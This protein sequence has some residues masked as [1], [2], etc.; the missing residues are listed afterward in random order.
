VATSD[1][2]FR[3]GACPTPEY[4]IAYTGNYTTSADAN[5]EARKRVFVDLLKWELPILADRFEVDQFDDGRA[6]YLIVAD[7]HRRHLASARLL[8]T[9]RPALLDSLFPD[10]V[11]GLP[12]QGSDV[13]EITRFCLSREAGA[14]GRRIARDTLLVGLAQFALSNGVRVYT[15]V[16]ELPWFQQ[17][18]TFGWD[19]RALGQSKDH[20]G[21]RLTALRID[22][23]EAT[24]AKLAA[25][26][27]VA[28]DGVMPAEAA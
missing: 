26:G 23:D 12:P 2:A 18:Q 17:I 6:T 20:N 27:I 13:L 9:T 8:E 10:L 28:D 5:F 25:A 16:A 21:R 14:Q 4:T 7:Q 11:D 15:G 1:A 19:C 3:G 24:P 22:I